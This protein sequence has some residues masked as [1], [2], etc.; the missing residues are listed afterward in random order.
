MDT[1]AWCQW[2]AE[3]E[4]CGSSPQ[5]E[6]LA[7]VVAES[8]ELLEWLLLLP[9]SRQQPNLLFASVRF[10]GG[11]TD[12]VDGFVDFVRSSFDE[13]EVTMLARSTQTNEVARC[14]AFLPLL[15][16]LDAELA[17]IEVGASAGL[18]LFPDLYAYSYDGEQIGNSDL[19]IDV[20]TANTVP[21]P[22]RLPTV[23]WRAG[24][25]LNPLSVSDDE[26]LAWLRACV[27]PEHTER[28]QR[29][30]LAATIVATDPPR[31]D[32]GDLCDATLNLIDEA[33]REAIKVVFHSAVLAYVDEASRLDF[34]ATMRS[35]VDDRS[36][37]VWLSN[38]GPS[39]IAGI[40]AA[41]LIVE[42]PGNAQFHLGRDG[43]ELIAVTDPHGRWLR[44]MPPC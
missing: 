36:D 8:D 37:V 29:L 19:V 5:Y 41:D 16:D 42:P 24:L 7:N 38:E 33:P 27:W 2:F 39:V 9:G 43:T 11:A 6:R 23:A 17:L 12:T 3:N 30:D 15:A 31:I 40:E 25:D 28:R 22:Q 10:L 4:A 18:C 32:Q 26:D 1:A 44:W 35:L 21:V 13:L 20:E 14:A 34:A